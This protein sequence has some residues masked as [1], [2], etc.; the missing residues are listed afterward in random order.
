VTPITVATNTA[1][2]PIPVG[3]APFAVAV[4]PD[5]STAYVANFSS[6]D[7]TP[8]AVA[9]NTAGTPIPVGNDPFGVAV[10]PDGATL[11]VTNSDDG[12]VTPIAVATN[13]AGTPIAVGSGPSGV[14]IASGQASPPS[15]PPAPVCPAAAQAS[16][17]EGTLAGAEGVIAVVP[18]GLLALFRRWR[19][20]GGS[21]PSGRRL[22]SVLTGLMVAGVGVLVLAACQPAKPLPPC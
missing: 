6:S 21:V 10:T 15:P 1:G 18:L 20:A 19:G 14:A 9:T 2:T 22:R 12:D 7:V 8:I 16:L 4:T 11:Y 5:G 3:D 13:T 17:G